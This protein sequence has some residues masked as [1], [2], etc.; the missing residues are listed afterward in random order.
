[1]CHF[2]L[3]VEALEHIRVEG[4]QSQ[5]QCPHSHASLSLTQAIPHDVLILVESIAE[6]TLHASEG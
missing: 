2:A 4:V 5:D 3:L 6:K 1:M